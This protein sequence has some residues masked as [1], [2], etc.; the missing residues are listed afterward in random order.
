MSSLVETLK[1]LEADLLADP[2]RIAAH[3]SMPFTIFRYPPAE[4][5]PLRRQLRLLSISL[6]NQGRRVTFLSLARL[7]WETIDMFN[8]EDVF[9]TEA[10]RGFDAAQGHVNRLMDSPDFRPAADGVLEKIGHLS[11]EKDVVFMVRAGGFAP[12]VYR[13]SCLLD[14]LHNRTLV[15]IVLFY[16]GS[17]EI[18]TDLRF[19]DLPV[20]GNLGD[21]NYRVRVYG[22][23]S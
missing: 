6:Q 4:E 10:F 12:Q 9:Q 14:G 8:K 21:Y 18:G 19:F 5:Y 23:E 20:L 11:P 13:T 1:Q 17:A 16:P 3:S 2:V 15:P 7:V 22:A